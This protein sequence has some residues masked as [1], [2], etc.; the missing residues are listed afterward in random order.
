MQLFLGIDIHSD[1]LKRSYLKRSPSK[2]RKSPSSSKASAREK[3][4][5]NQSSTGFSMNA[6][7]ENISS[8]RSDSKRN[9]ERKHNDLLENKYFQE[10]IV[11]ALKARL[12][13]QIDTQQNAKSRNVVKEITPMQTKEDSSDDGI[14]GNTRFIWK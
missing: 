13:D 12:N 10:E 3:R 14:E 4:S 6:Q 11:K 7:K 1:F 9:D 2:L 5:Q 8:L